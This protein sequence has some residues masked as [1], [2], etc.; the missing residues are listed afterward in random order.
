[1]DSLEKHLLIG[2]IGF[3]AVI[4]FGGVTCAIKTNE[5][6]AQVMEKCLEKAQPSECALAARTAVTE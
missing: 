4:F 1:M 6:R 2:F 5:Q 3:V